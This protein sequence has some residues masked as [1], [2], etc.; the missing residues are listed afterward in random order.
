MDKK[1]FKV[2]TLKQLK[3]VVEAA[4]MEL[5][6]WGVHHMIIFK[7]PKGSETCGTY[8]LEEV[9]DMIQDMAKA[10]EKGDIEHE[11]TKEVNHD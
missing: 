5:A 8:S 1:R 4:S 10:I 7:T 2:E 3:V 6:R 11:G 9:K